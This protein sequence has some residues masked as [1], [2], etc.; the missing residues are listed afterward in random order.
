MPSYTVFLSN[1]RVSLKAGREELTAQSTVEAE[2]VTLV[3]AMKKAVLS[4]N[5]MKELECF[6]VF[7]WSASSVPKIEMSTHEKRKG[8]CWMPV[9]AIFTR[10]GELHV[11]IMFASAGVVSVLLT[12]RCVGSVE[13]ATEQITP[14]F[15]HYVIC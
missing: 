2:L 13:Q 5:M 7:S 14:C 9:F 15:P 1:A 4:S 3:L 12:L 10:M 11:S 8:F 6:G